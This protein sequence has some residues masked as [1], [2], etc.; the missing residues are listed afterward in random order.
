M[1]KEDLDKVGLARGGVFSREHPGEFAKDSTLGD[2]LLS[3]YWDPKK[4][5]FNVGMNKQLDGAL[6][7]AQA[8]AMMAVLV[9]AINRA[10]TQ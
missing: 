7:D 9:D 5:Q 8:E 2:L 10:R 1:A 6:T 3:L 4:E